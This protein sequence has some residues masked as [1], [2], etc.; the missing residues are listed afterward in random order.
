MC[1]V[2]AD[3]HWHGTVVVRVRADTLRRLGL[4]PDRP[5]SAPADPMPPKWGGHGRVDP[6]SVIVGQVDD[7]RALSPDR[8]DRA[9]WGVT[10]VMGEGGR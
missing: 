6:R 10:S 4:H 2:R 9:G 3:G 8:A 5:A 1:G 7:L